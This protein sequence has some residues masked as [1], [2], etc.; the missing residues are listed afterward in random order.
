MSKK[1]FWKLLAWILAVL[2]TGMMLANPSG[3][4]NVPLQ[5][6]AFTTSCLFCIGVGRTIVSP[7][8]APLLLGR[9]SERRICVR[10]LI[11]GSIIS[12]LLGL[13]FLLPEVRQN[14][15][16]WVLTPVIALTPILIVPE[17]IMRAR[18][19]AERAQCSVDSKLEIPF[20]TT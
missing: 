12:V 6:T 8:A 5:L 11:F 4:F 14:P 20:R 7:K 10:Q 3:T 2:L 17:V 9:K 19:S 15:V 1:L 16:P 18:T 13:L